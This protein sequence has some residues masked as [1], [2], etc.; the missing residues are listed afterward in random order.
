MV[1][2][3]EFSSEDESRKQANLK[4]I[5]KTKDDHEKP[6]ENDEND[7]AL[8]TKEMTLSN[9]GNDIFIGDSAATSHMTNNK[10]GVYDLTPIRG[11]VMIGNGES[12][13]CTHKGKLDV[14]CKHRD[15]SMAR[16]TWDVKIVPQLNHDLFSFTKAM[17]EGW[18]MNGRWKEGGLT[19]ELFKTT[20]ASMKFDRM[21]PSGSS[22][23]MGIKTQRL[24]G[25]AHAV[26]EPG[27]SIPIWKFHQMTGHT[28]EH[29]LKPTA[30]NMGI[31]L[32]GKLEPCKICEQVKIRQANVPKKKEKQVPS[33]PGYRMFI[34][35]TSFIHESMG[36]KRHWLIAVD[37][38]SD[39]SHSFFL[40]KKSD[41]TVMIPIWIK[42]LK[43]KYGIGVKNIRLDNSG[44][45]RNLQKECEKQNLGI[46]F[47]FTA[48]GTPQQ[49]SVVERK[50]PTLMG[51]SRAMMIEAGFSQQ[52][53]RKFWCEVISLETKLDNIMV[54]KERT[55]PPYTMFYNE[56]ARYKQYLRSFGEMAVIAIGDGGKMRSKL[57]TRGRT[58]IF[59]GYADDHAGNVYR[60]INI[61]MKKIILSRDIQWLNSFWKQYKKRKDD[62]KKLVD[63]FYPNDEDDQTQE[64]SEIE[65]TKNSGDGNN[66]EEQKKLGI[67]IEMIGARKEEFG[68]TRIQTKEMMSPK[69]E[70]MERA[71]LTMEDWIHETCLISVVTSGPTEPKTFQEAWHSP[72]EEE[73]QNWQIAI[74]K[75]IRSMINRGVWRK[76]DRAKIPQNRRL[77]GNK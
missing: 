17:K 70:S 52:D 9:I 40:R 61:Q 7:K 22:W 15:G 11:S 76:I 29:L 3:Y 8:V 72:V 50:I 21:I 44:E 65:E 58:G 33:R 63:E 59:V 71:E 19:I 48:P 46:I 75:E 2:Y 39:S 74:R 4:K 38:F 66:T 14:I 5:K 77:I 69:Y 24:V 54:R 25:Q 16:E 27:K 32:T 64:E 20:R 42:G 31:K 30:E 67:D 23:L 37:E 10:T 62:S 56:E 68:R 73:R 53:K 12:I 45:N 47:E 18:Q 36:G 41:Q 55:K 26:I 1:H 35:I 57:D 28:G 49:N 6:R 43:T 51:R 13:S 60:F 34:D